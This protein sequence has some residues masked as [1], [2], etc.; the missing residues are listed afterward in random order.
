[1]PLKQLKDKVSKQRNPALGTIDEHIERIKR[2]IRIFDIVPT[3]PGGMKNGNG[4]MNRT[5]TYEELIT[6]QQNPEAL[7][8]SEKMNIQQ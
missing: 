7:E 4:V 8:S 6:M 3:K 5:F 1:L 2:I